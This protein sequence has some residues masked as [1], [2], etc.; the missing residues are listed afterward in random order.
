MKRRF[1]LAA[2]AAPWLG[3]CG[4][5]VPRIGKLGAGDIVLAFGD[6]LTHG[7]GARAEESYPAV[8]WCAPACPASRLPAASRGFQVSQFF[9]CHSVR[10]AFCQLRSLTSLPSV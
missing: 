2:L 9:A 7:T 1:F 4:N 6:S 3:G 5:D 10:S 8:R